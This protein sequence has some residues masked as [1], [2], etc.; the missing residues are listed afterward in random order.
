MFHIDILANFIPW[1]DLYL[2][3]KYVFLSSEIKFNSKYV[4]FM[5]CLFYFSVYI[6]WY[7]WTLPAFNTFAE[8]FSLVQRIFPAGSIFLEQ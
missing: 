8:R 7:F 5:F 4:R 3:Q 1:F 6:I 2:I